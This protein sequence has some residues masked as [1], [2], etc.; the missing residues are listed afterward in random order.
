MVSRRF[1]QWFPHARRF[2]L[3]RPRSHAGRNRW[4]GGLYVVVRK[5]VRRRYYPSRAPRT[6]S[7][8]LFRPRRG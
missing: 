4:R 1:P 5:A 7:R 6:L 8:R 3:G 2:F